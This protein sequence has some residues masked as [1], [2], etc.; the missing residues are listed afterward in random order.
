MSSRTMENCRLIKESGSPGLENG[1]CIGFAQSYENDEPPEVCK[2]CKLHYLY[3]DGKEQPLK[4]WCVTED[5]HE[6][7]SK[8]VFAETRGKA[9]AEGAVLLD[10]DF[11][12]VSVDREKKYDQYA[13][14]GE[15]PKS[16]LISDG[17]WFTCCECE[18]M[19]DKDALL[20]G[21][22]VNDNEVYC[23]DCMKELDLR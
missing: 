7:Y 13:D 23:A 3:E 2:E 8:I 5:G 10:R 16:V 22:E 4:A 12:E 21:G 17:W 11:M 9:K 18:K 6:G 1:K 20:K 14:R 19:V 15:V